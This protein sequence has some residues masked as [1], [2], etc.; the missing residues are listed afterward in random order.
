M[1]FGKDVVDAKR[2]KR[3]K[4]FK[5]IYFISPPPPQSFHLSSLFHHMCSYTLSQAIVEKHKRGATRQPDPAT[6]PKYDDDMFDISENL[7][8]PLP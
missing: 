8:F 2:V 5:N 1:A 6:K 7:L 3:E 4:L